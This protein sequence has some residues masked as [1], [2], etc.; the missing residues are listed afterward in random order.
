MLPA[1]NRLRRAPDFAVAVRGGR[2]SGRNALVLHLRAPS[3]AGV[4]AVDNPARVG[5]VVGK[6]VGPAVVRNQVKRRLRALLRS[7]LDLL[8]AGSVLV[9]R[10]LPPAG[11]ARSSALAA[12]L[13]AGLARLLPTAPP[14]TAR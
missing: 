8:P 13:D 6:T 5:L 3:G 7:R 10:A 9:V 4:D 11:T 1:G 2:R 12:D 14:G